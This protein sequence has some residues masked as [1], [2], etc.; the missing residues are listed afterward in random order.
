MTELGKPWLRS[1]LVLAALAL[2]A[3][4]GMEL[5]TRTPQ[6]VITP[7]LQLSAS[8]TRLVIV[9][10]GSMDAANPQFAV[11]LERLRNR[12]AA[13]AGTQVRFLRWEPWANV[14]LRAAASARLLGEGLGM[15]L[16]ALPAL[17]DL[18]LIVHS[19]GA[20]VA[21]TLCESYR[22]NAATPAR[23]EM[24]FLDAFQ[25]DGF[26]DWSHGARTHGRC[27]DFA[28]AIFNTDDP[29]PATNRPLQHAYNL[30]VTGLP[31]PT[32][33]SGNG[34]DWPVEY[35]LEA[36]LHPELLPQI[37]DHATYPRG[38][39]VKASALP[40]GIAVPDPAVAR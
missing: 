21:D 26:V 6:S 27:A 9:V 12:Y 22:Q 4:G 8:T 29:A 1:L 31:V 2:V 38:Q 13:D 16:A 35:Y 37:P 17:A 32:G 5:Y 23:I 30:D 39:V 3:I 19:S 34:H 33:F 25:I 24:V 7:D 28:M 18:Q 14:R 15:E 40:A 11:L 10:H 36:L 20:Y